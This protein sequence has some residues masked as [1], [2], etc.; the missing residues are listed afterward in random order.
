MFQLE[1]TRLRLIP[2]NTTQLQLHAADYEALQRSLGLVPRQ[3][4]MEE[5]FQ[6]EFDDALANFWLPET[7]ANASRYEWF[8]NWLIIYKADNCVAGGIGVTGLPNDRGETEIGYGIDQGYRGRGIAAEALECM[9]KWVFKH[10]ASE[11]L[12]A[13][14]PVA[15]VNSQ[16]VLQKAGFKQ[17]RESEGLILWRKLNSN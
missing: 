12:I 13:H 9:A 14:T 16:R 17:I 8:T 7:A 2:L 4:Q 1:S 5:Y 15:L 10:P 11:A 3:M 6:N